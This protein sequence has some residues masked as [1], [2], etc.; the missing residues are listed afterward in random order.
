MSLY[1]QNSKIQSK[2][3]KAFQIKSES[4]LY[5]TYSQKLKIWSKIYR[6]G[7]KEKYV[8]KSYQKYKKLEVKTERN[9]R[10]KILK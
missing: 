2:N 5:T 6:K 7:F 1:Q 4:I 8:T 3:R 9:L 10:D